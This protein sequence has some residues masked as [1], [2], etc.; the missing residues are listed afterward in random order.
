M[1]VRVC[2]CLC[3]RAYVRACNAWSRARACVCGRLNI[4]GMAQT[5]YSTTQEDF[6]NFPREKAR[7][8]ISFQM[9]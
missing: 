3:V 4:S 7:K 8:Q 2:V 1:I 6:L 5:V 9:I